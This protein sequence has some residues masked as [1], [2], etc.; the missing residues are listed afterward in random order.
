[1]YRSAN[2]GFL[3]PFT[4]MA[5]EVD[6]AETAMPKIEKRPPSEEL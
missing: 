6:K 4:S 1:M 5:E 2:Q 3:K